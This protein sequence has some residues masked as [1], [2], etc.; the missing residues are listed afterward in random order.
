MTPIILVHGAWHGAWCWLRVLRELEF[1]QRGAAAIDLPGMGEDTTPP[2]DVSLDLWAEAIGET[3]KTLNKPAL[4]VGHSMGGMA[5]SQAAELNP[6]L[7]AGLVYL[8][9]YL[10][11][12]GDTLL[13]MAGRATPGTSL[14]EPVFSADGATV[15]ASDACLRPAFYADCTDQ[16]FLFAK[17]RPK[18]MSVRPAVE[19]VHLTAER[20]GRVPRHYI[21]CLND[22]AVPI[23]QQRAMVAA[24]PCR[25]VHTLDTGHSPFL[26]APDKLTDIL[27]AL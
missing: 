25:S 14:V 8:C 22:R 18:P 15:S 21:E 20:F 2:A 23:D 11:Q 1:R 19:P 12:D 6:D 3:L 27:V 10:P 4:L 13:D 16:D 24:S 9:A 26:S 17:S 7:I 5:I